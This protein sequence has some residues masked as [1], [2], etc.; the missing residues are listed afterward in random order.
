MESEALNYNAAASASDSS[1]IMPVYAITPFYYA[2]P[3]CP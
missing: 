1:C 3:A 2:Y